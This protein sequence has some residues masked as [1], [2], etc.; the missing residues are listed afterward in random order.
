MIS[1][2]GL[3]RTLLFIR[4]TDGQG[5]FY[6]NIRNPDLNQNVRTHR[7]T[8]ALARA[9][10]DACTWICIGGHNQLD[11]KYP[12]VVH[13]NLLSILFSFLSAS[14]RQELR[15]VYK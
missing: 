10:T 9:H 8:H 3:E 12:L 2:Y 6:R 7:Q 5:H 15:A 1:E 13:C 14:T 4:T 11:E